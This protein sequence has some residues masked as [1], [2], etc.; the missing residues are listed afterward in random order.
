MTG[1]LE[2]DPRALR[3]PAHPGYFAD[4]FVVRAPDGGYAAFGTQPGDGSPGH[5]F[6][7]LL[8]EDLRAWKSGGLA[9]GRLAPELGDEYWAP[10][11]CWRD[12]AWWMY[13]SVGRGIEGHHLRVARSESLTGPF[14]DLGVNLTD[15]LTFAIDP[16]PFQDAD[17]H[18]YL[19]FARD[20][21][22]SPR[23]GT[24][25]AVGRLDS[26]TTLTDVRA[27]LAP[28]A[29]WQI[30]ERNRHMYGA[31]Y[32]WHT[33]EGPSVVRR[34]GRYWMTFSGGAW[35]GPGYAVS[36][37][38]A[39][40]PLGPWTHA[41]DTSASVLETGPA[42]IGPGHNSLVVGPDGR[43]VIAFHAWSGDGLNREFHLASIDFTPD[44]PTVDLS[45]SGSRGASDQ[46]RT[47]SEVGWDH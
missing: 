12:G 28:N 19:Y 41:P 47:D 34:H 29:D 33:L 30:Y 37:A 31:V 40:E 7:V 46:A 42:L 16:H 5:V 9:L 25:L 36:W 24:H 35:T 1:A 26:P 45:D 6:T 2:P 44:G 8:S 3:S 14:T 43:D 39:P 27:A 18:W 17:G 32:D 10:E 38:T 21:L 20:V 23:P 13:Y 15:A 4:P 11:A 22:D